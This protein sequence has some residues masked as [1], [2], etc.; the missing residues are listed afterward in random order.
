[1]LVYY[2]HKKH[3]ARDHAKRTKERRKGV[4]EYK[5]RKKLCVG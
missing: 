5:G 1:M 3:R 4:K 2:E